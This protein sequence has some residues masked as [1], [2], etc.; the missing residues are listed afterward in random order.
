MVLMGRPQ[1]YQD[2]ALTFSLPE[3]V[4]EAVSLAGA[5]LVLELV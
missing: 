1:P 2:P 3:A 5:V 4:E